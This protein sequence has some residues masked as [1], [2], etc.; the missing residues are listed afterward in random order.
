[1]LGEDLR[2]HLL[3]VVELGEVAG[4]DVSLTAGLLDLGLR[5]LELVG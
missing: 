3:D 5:L 2:R 1:M 4:V